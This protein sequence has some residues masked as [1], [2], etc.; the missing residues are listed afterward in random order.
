[1]SI[2]GYGPEIRQK[3]RDLYKERDRLFNTWNSELLVFITAG[4]KAEEL[5]CSYESDT[6][7]IF[8]SPYV[9]CMENSFDHTN[10]PCH[11][12]ILEMNFQNTS[13]GYCRVL[14]GRLAPRCHAAI[15]NSLCE[16]ECGHSIL[17]SA[18]YVETSGMHPVR[19]TTHVLV[20]RCHG[21]MVFL[22]MIRYTPFAVNVQTY[23]RH[24]PIEL[25]TGH[26]QIL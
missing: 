7:I 4:S 18:L 25:V 5:T 12:T 11:F 10:I 9:M 1:M 19:S 14:L 16:N 2:L 21:L 22:K 26:H 3:R 23:C 15:P 17:S 13:A 20:H 8:V 24:G 6:D